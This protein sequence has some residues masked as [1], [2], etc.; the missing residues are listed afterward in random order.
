MRSSAFLLN[1]RL[2][3]GEMWLDL[4]DEIP[5]ELSQSRCW[6]PSPTSV[7]FSATLFEQSKAWFGFRLGP[8][9]VGESVAA[10]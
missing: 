9:R 5:F 10:E 2:L 6:G 7:Y 1:A 8:N 4:I 3:R